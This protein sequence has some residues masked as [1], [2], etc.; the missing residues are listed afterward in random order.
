MPDWL[1]GVLVVLI[2]FPLGVWAIVYALIRLIARV[3]AK[4]GYPASL[5]LVPALALA[6]PPDVL[7]IQHAYDGPIEQAGTV[8]VFR[9][10]GA[11]MLVEWVDTT[12]DPIFR[13]SFDNF[14]DPR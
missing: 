12:T 6:S 13:N 4:I 10:L 1:P 11:T 9:Y 2:L 5:L 14:G 3:G 8:T 7:L